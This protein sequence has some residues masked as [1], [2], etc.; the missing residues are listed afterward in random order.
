MTQVLTSMS[1]ALAETVAAGGAS[2]VRVEARDRVP[3]SGI[4]WPGQG[5]FVTAHHV[6]ERD[7]NITVGLPNGE[8]VTATLAGRDPTTDLAVLRAEVGGLPEPTWADPD[9]LR[10]GH[11]V[12]ALGAQLS[13]NGV[14]VELYGMIADVQ[15]DGDGLVGEPLGQQPQHLQLSL[16]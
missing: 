3:A 2:V 5:V 10:V 7:E 11:L 1:E 6:V 4:V 9:G 14:D 15:P 13:Q 8:A 16:G 12:L